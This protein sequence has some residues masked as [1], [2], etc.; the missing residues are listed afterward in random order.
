MLIESLAVPKNY[1]CAEVACM[2][3]F[4][5]TLGLYIVGCWHE[6]LLSDLVETC[7]L[8]GYESLATRLLIHSVMLPASPNY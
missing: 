1:F 5:T 3:L 7:C 2:A 4:R 6:R 8:V